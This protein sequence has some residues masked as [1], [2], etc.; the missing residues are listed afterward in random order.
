MDAG[1]Y[2]FP[3]ALKVRSL[4]SSVIVL[5]DRSPFSSPMSTTHLR[6]KN[7]QDS[8]FGIFG[9]HR[10][11]DRVYNRGYEA[12]NTS[13]HIGPLLYPLKVKEEAIN[14]GHW[15]AS[16]GKQTDKEWTYRTT[17][18]RDKKH[19]LA[20]VRGK[21]FKQCYCPGKEQPAYTIVKTLTL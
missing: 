11:M 16:F 5:T 9:Q 1:H 10:W 17:L 15:R 3:F 12:G 2:E 6:W 14:T 7:L 21:L 8:E 18:A 19:A 20:E 4:V 13:L